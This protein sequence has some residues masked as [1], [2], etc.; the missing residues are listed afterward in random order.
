MQVP[1]CCNLRSVPWLALNDCQPSVRV[2][3]G[4]ADIGPEKVQLCIK[5]LTARRESLICCWWVSTLVFFEDLTNDSRGNR[6]GFGQAMEDW[7][8]LCKVVE[9]NWRSCC[10]GQSSALHMQG[11]QADF[12]DQ[13]AFPNERHVSKGNDVTKP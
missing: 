3:F 11:A 12:G 9:W 5:V 10:H 2:A 6:S 13:L 1:W 4:V 8:L 7:R